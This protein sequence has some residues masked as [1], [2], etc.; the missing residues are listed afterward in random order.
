MVTHPIADSWRPGGAHGGRRS[1]P[2]TGAASCPLG[3]WSFGLCEL[4]GGLTGC[5]RRGGAAETILVR[6]NR[7][8]R[9]RLFMGSEIAWPRRGTRVG[10][11][12]R[13]EGRG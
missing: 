1:L 13:S 3:G 7:C 5:V 2:A 8:G 4:N 6:V 10:A 11:G 9:L 12:T